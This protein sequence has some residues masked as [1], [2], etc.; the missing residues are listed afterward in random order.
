MSLR[1]VLWAVVPLALSSTIPAASPLVYW[2]ARNVVGVTPGTIVADWVG[3][4]A[5]VTVSNNFSYI[6]ARI[7]DHCSNGN[8]FIVRMRNAEGVQSLDVATLYTSNEQVDY[9]LFASAGRLSFSGDNATFSLIKAVEARFSQCA[10]GG[11]LTF[12]SF[13]SDG[14]FLPPPVPERRIEVIGGLN[15]SCLSAILLLWCRN[16][17]L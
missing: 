6:S 14:E 15:A 12:V 4:S 13:S 2:S 3:T 9:I 7:A 5:T 10:S 11:N 1:S 16:R 17:T 8:K